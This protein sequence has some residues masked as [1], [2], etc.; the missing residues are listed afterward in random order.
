MLSDLEVH[1]DDVLVHTVGDVVVV[2]VL[3]N[4]FFSVVFACIYNTIIFCRKSL[5]SMT[6]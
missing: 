3:L 6:K 2:E 1:V 5:I 4:S